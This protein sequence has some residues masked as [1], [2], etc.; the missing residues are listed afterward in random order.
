MA[1][2]AAPAKEGPEP[3][4]SKAAA[5]APLC[6]A[7]I[8][9]A[10]NGAD[11]AALLYQRA[12]R[13]NEEGRFEQALRDL[14]EAISYEFRTPKYLQERAF[15]LDSLGE[16]RRALADADSEIALGGDDVS[17]A[18]AE[19]AFAR[20]RLGD[21]QGA[22]EDRD[23][24][25][26]LKP[27]DAT[28]LVARA[29]AALWLH[30]F[31]DARRDLDAASARAR[32]GKKDKKLLD[33]VAEGRADLANW[34]GSAGVR[35][36]A[37]CEKAIAAEQYRRPDLVADCTAAFFA[38]RTPQERA[39]A[40]AHRALAFLFGLSDG[41]D[42]WF[43]RQVAVGLDPGNADWPYFAGLSSL[44]A[45]RFEVAKRMFERSLAIKRS[46][47]ALAGRG[48]ARYGLGDKAGAAA[49]AHAA[50]AIAPHPM[51]YLLLGRIAFDAG[52]A[53]AA[54]AYWLDSWRHGWRDDDL[55]ARLKA[56]GVDDP[57]KEAKS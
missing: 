30:R 44:D 2:A 7:A 56:V 9:R 42:A 26:R 3:C 35:D 14:D 21:F 51:T 29:Q 57:D 47:G 28:S 18:Y 8:A 43:D 1:L 40:L 24:V 50:Q 19:R 6:A 41:T 48:A 36:P 54:K 5:D 45:E 13:A 53:K 31:D 25:V 32:R 52:D 49:D 46:A 33:Y 17:M 10:N 20:V 12:Y 38:A 27:G 15:T 23:Q 16:Y 4:S 11:K 55:R 22:W 37:A 34:T 39:Q